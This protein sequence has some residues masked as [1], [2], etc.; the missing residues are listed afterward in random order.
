V[1]PNLLFLPGLL[2]DAD[3]FKPLI[4]GLGPRVTSSIADL[5]RSDTIAGLARD[6]LSQAPPGRFALAGHSMGGYVALEVMRQAPGRVERLALLN[7]HARP[8]SP[9]ATENRRRLLALAERDFPAVIAA[10][11][12]KLMTPSHLQDPTLVGIVDSMAL[13]VGKEAFR[14]QQEAIIHR[15]DSRPHL[16]AIACPTAVIAARNDQLMPVE[17]LKELADGIPAARL[18]VIEDSGHMAPIE[19]PARVL[20]AILPW[21]ERKTT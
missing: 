1:T 8:D 5:T 6:A 12:P 14:R 19:Q 18:T 2:E 9:E 16:K 11:L 3:A 4:E 10:L 20:E 13:A 7:T 15:I 21:L 17:L